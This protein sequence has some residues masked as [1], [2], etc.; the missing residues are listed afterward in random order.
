[1]S[2]YV[3]VCHVAKTRSEQVILYMD[4]ASFLELDLSMRMNSGMLSEHQMEIG[5]NREYRAGQHGQR[6][7]C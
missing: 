2:S 4:Y 5:W 3:C 7:R 1:M 6:T